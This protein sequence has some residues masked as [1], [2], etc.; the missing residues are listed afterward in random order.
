MAH[1]TRIARECTVASLADAVTNPLNLAVPRTR[2]K[3]RP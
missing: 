2:R 3:R 1:V